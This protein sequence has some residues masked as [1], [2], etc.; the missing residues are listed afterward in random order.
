L[1]YN[2][3]SDNEKLNEFKDVSLTTAAV[4]TAY[5]RIYMSKIK[6]DILNKGGNVYYTD[7]DSIVTDITLD[8]KLVGN[9]LGQFKLEH[10][11]KEGYFI[12]NKTYCLQLFEKFYDKYLDE[13]RDYIIKSKSVDRESL[14][15]NDFINL[16]KGISLEA[17][18]RSA[19]SNYSKG[20]V[21]IVDD[22]IQVNHDS[23]TKREKIFK[24]S[25][26]VDTKPLILKNSIL[27][28]KPS[29]KS[30]LT[31][32]TNFISSENTSNKDKSDSKKKNK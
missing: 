32:L 27:E 29:K 20:S 7:T 25:K 8:D 9:G 13:W 12:S 2:V 31:K 5:A 17:T 6:L 4:V 18:K 23:Y 11:V 19:I 22:K 14:K 21:L 15:V 28:I 10:K 26:W 16:Y 30:K 1:N 3:N 24:R